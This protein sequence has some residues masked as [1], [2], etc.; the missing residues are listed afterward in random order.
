MLKDLVRL[1][2]AAPV[3][4]FLVLRLFCCILFVLHDVEMQ[5]GQ[6]TNSLIIFETDGPQSLKLY[7][8]SMRLFRIS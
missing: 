5:I 2:C 6:P 1:L 7:K 3:G 8:V 4:E